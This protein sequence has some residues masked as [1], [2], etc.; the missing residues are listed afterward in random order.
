MIKNPWDSY[1]TKLNVEKIFLVS[2]TD[3]SNFTQ[4][5]TDSTLYDILYYHVST[6]TLYST[7]HKLSLHYIGEIQQRKE[8][9][10]NYTYEMMW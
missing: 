1:S 8:S 2:L 9:H 4:K 7:V 3:T 6:I 5:F 10:S